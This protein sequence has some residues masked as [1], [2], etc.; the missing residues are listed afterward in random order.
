MQ[1]SVQWKRKEDKR[2]IDVYLFLFR[3]VLVF[4]FTPS[5]RFGDAALDEEYVSTHFLATSKECFFSGFS[6]L[7]WY[8][9]EAFHAQLSSD[10]LFT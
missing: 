1:T 2:Y 4:F 3:K 6:Y 10:L 5:S 8:N 9:I 7:A